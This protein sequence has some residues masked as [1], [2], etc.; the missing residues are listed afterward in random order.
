MRRFLLLTG[1]AVCLSGAAMCMVE[2][3]AFAAAQCILPGTTDSSGNLVS[4]GG[5]CNGNNGFGN[6]TEPTCTLVG[7]ETVCTQPAPGGTDTPPGKSNPN[8]VKPKGNQR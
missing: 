5:P 7:T 3:S 4:P 8:L 2:K 1:A 6:G